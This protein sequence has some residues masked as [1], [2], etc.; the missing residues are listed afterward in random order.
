[1]KEL[2]F[3]K[4]GS[5]TYIA[6]LLLVAI[7]L[8]LGGCQQVKETNLDDNYRVVHNSEDQAIIDMAKAT[9]TKHL[10][11]EYAL[12]VEITG[13][14]LLPAYVT[15]EV[16]FEGNVVGNKEQ[17][18]NIFINYNKNEISELGMSPELIAA[19]RAKGYEPFDNR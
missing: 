10:K 7:T 5:S 2:I 8:M 19:I 3:I 13:E 16:I 11:D 17:S 15:T 1:M 14:K 12:E 18:F 6:I 4:V 9:A